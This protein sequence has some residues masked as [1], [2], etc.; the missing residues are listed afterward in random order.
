[1]KIRTIAATLASTALL[2]AG[3]LAPSSATAAEPTGTKSLAAV[4]TADGNQFDRNSSDYDILTEAV[5]AV[6]K[7]KPDSAVSV[8]T[9]GNV[10]LTAFLPNDFSFKLLAKDLTGKYRWSEKATFQSLVDA[11]GVD[12]IEQVLLY[13]VVPGATIDSA[14]ALRSDN[15][16]LTTAQG[17]KFTVDVISKRFG[18]VQLRDQDR[19]D[20]DPLLVPGKLDINKGNK[21]IAHGIFLV[22]RPLD[23]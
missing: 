5:L 9:D 6:L 20:F 17:G 8:L 10:A 12:T 18:I 15:A 21:Q 3:V 11:V 16:A 4:L 14:T 19:N 13:H 2:S 22:L 23:I 7:A 1:M